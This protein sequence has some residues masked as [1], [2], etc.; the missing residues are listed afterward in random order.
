MAGL[1]TQ[2]SPGNY[3]GPA[4]GGVEW[5]WCETLLL[6]LLQGADIA[7]LLQNRPPPFHPT[8][9]TLGVCY[10]QSGPL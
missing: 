4:P 7:A 1:G 2:T 8:G 5:C 10:Y 6:L 9:K 3:V